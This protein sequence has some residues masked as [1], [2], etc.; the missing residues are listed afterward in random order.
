MEKAKI[1]ATGDGKYV[2]TGDAK[3]IDLLIR[4]NRV[5][6]SRGLLNFEKVN[7]KGKSR[8]DPLPG[9]KPDIEGKEE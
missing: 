2:V 6:I 5:R 3:Q 8:P 9:Q 4:E 7:P 1:T